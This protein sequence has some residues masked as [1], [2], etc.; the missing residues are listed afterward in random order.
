MSA[1]PVVGPALDCAAIVFRAIRKSWFD[2]MTGQIS[3]A[4]FLLRSVDT[5]GLSVAISELCTPEQAAAVLTRCPGVASLHTGKIRNTDSELNVV[6]DLD[7]ATHALITG[8]P[9][10]ENDRLRSEML[11]GRLRDQARF[12][13]VA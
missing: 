6:A 12:I 8:L 9:I 4:A 7:D 13:P 11:A 10:P 3:E 5:D 2:P 1:P